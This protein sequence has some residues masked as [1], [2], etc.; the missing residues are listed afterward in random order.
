MS[1]GGEGMGGPLHQVGWALLGRQLWGDRP[2]RRLEVGIP[3]RNSGAEALRRVPARGS[4]N[5]SL[6]R[7][8][9]GG[10][11]GGGG[12]GRQWKRRGRE[13]AAAEPGPVGHSGPLLCPLPSWLVTPRPSSHCL[14]PWTPSLVKV[15]GNCLSPA[16]L[17]LTVLFLAPPLHVCVSSLLFF[18]L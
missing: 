9:D 2:R 12:G 16:L 11:G 15:P 17:P 8:E 14:H 10:G 5:R 1:D 4:R 13:A 6:A 3:D 7:T 18:T